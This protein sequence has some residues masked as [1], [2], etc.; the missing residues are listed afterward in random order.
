[1]NV[2]CIIQARVGSTRLPKKV[3]KKICNK[4]V[5]EHDIDRIKKVKN[6]DSIVIATTT[7]DKDIE[8]VNEAKR[9]KVNYFRGSEN[10]VLARYYFAAKENNA[11][12][13]VRMTSDCPL[14]DPGVTEAIIQ[15][16]LEKS[17]MYDYVSNTLERTYP[18]GLDIEVFSFS[19]LEKAFNE[20]KLDSDREHVTPYIWRNG[21]VFRIFQYKNEKDYS[22][23]RLTLDTD[24]DFELIEKVYG[25]LY[26]S[27]KDF[28]LYDIID[29]FNKRPE[30]KMINKEVE[31]KKVNDGLYL[32]KVDETDCELIFYWANDKDTRD[33]S[34]NS[35]KIDWAEHKEWFR[36]KISSTEDFY[37][38]KSYEENIGQ[39]RI[40][41]T[42]SGL[43]LNYSIDKSYRGKG[44][45]K[46]II[47][48]T[49]KKIA[50]KYSGQYLTAYVKSIN[51]RS[52]SIF[53]S[54]GYGEEFRDG[55]YK[56]TKKQ[57]DVV[58]K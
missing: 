12:V 3:L 6:I 21:E 17:D 20:A 28:D 46:K 14:I 56:F 4:T 35:D 45:G 51:D 49:E 55:C 23:L 52:I 22:D 18:R 44:Y 33:N 36:K 2:V 50:D 27:K 9:L 48:L 24:E 38:L 54:L 39:V 11:D 19:A 15:C 40:D 7:E 58:D 13:V 57:G 16:Y 34:F 31:Q 1:M 42:D 8:I 29:L 32:R 43:V 53:R 26:L 5:L 47:E 41:K 10:D 25:E 37:I 30:L